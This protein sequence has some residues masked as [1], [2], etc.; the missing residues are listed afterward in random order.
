MHY[1]VDRL[2]VPRFRFWPARLWVHV[3]MDKTA[4]TLSER[5]CIAE[6][7]DVATKKKSRLEFSYL[8]RR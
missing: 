2:L 1:S 3:S 4:D 6:R 8:R 7:I 5:H